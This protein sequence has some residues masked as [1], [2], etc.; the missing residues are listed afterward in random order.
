MASKSVFIRKA[1]LL[2]TAAPAVLLLVSPAMA[3]DQ[4]AA[5]ATAAPVDPQMQSA[6]QG[7]QSQDIV[8]TGS[9]FRR[10][11]TETP[12]PVT[13]L[14]TENLQRAGITN[15]ADAVRSISADNSG[16]IP[17]AF[18]G[19]FGSGSAGV[20]LRGL[21]V[22]STLVL[23]DGIRTTN[24]PAADDGQRS[25]VDLNSIPRSTIDRIE[26]LKDGASSTY[27]AD[28][29]GGVVNIITRKEIKGIEGTVEGGISQRGDGGEQ[30]LTLTA[31]Y[32]DLS[33]QGF[34]VYLNGEYEH[35][36]L[37]GVADR[38]FPYNTTDLTSIGG[39]NNNVGAFGAF[40]ARVGTIS[41]VVRP[42]TQLIPGNPY[43]GV[44][45]PNT[46][47]Q[48]LNPAG[49]AVGTIARNDPTTLEN[50]GN[51][52][53]Y[54]E[55]NQA[56][57]GTIAPEQTRYGFTGHA[58]I[59]VGADSQ[60]YVTGSY[61]HSTVFS[62]NSAPT[63]IRQRNPINSTNIVLPALLANGSINPQDPYANII[64][65]VT[66]Q[67]EAAQIQYA[68]GDIPATF[69]SDNNVY[70]LAAG[71]SGKFGQGWSYS[72]DAT[73]ARSDLTGVNKGY[74]SISGLADAINNGTYNFI[75]P[76]Q[77]SQAVRNS[78]APDVISK[79]KSEMYM[80]QAVVTKDLFN[81]PG[82]PLQIGV[83]G[84]IRRETLDNPNAN[85]SL[86]FLGLNAVSAS[87][88][89]TVSA[90]FFEI[91][92]PLLD[93]LEI[94]ASGRYD[95]YSDGF[96]RFSPKVGVKVTPFKSLA[97]R[98]TFS[99]GFR[100]PS[101]AESQKG[102]VIGYTTATPPCSVIIAHGGVSTGTDP[103]GNPTCSG[104]NG[105][106]Q[107]YSIGYNN[108]SNPS[109]KPEKSRSFTGGA[110]F[111]PTHWLS[112]TA[113]YYNIKKTDVISGGPESGAALANY[114]DGQP[115]PAGYSVTLDDPD[116]QFP[117]A[118]RKVLIVNSPYANASALKTSGIDVSVQ[119]DFKFGENNRFTSR[120]EGTEILT[121]DFKPSATA[122]YDHYVGT[123]APYA[124]SSGSG[125]PRWRA[126]WQ[127]SLQLGAFT[128]TGTGYY[129][130]GYKSVAVDQNGPTAIT[131][132]DSLYGAGANFCHTKGFFDLD[133]VGQ[134]KVNDKFSFYMNAINV[135]D[136]KPP[137]NPANYAAVNYNATWSQAGI[138][139]RYFR[140]GANFKF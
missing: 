83:G 55:Q 105:Y 126:N 10:P 111:Q 135:L 26:V 16:S 112:F 104:G 107:A 3:Q 100:A 140:V 47:S 131:C 108:A 4:P 97:L 70:R 68:F 18:A 53:A 29:I 77:N 94:N 133:L 106:V 1:H 32:G 136:A 130:S 5:P 22:N 132:T 44:A 40:G 35:D 125:T 117:N 14:S 88:K 91:N 110:I 9:L 95:H 71:I 30:R 79:A 138:I 114:Y 69:K 46:L 78:I 90:A 15:I 121:F 124:I 42:A 11:D 134:V 122:G 123:Q 2:A 67:R 58:T 39:L 129:T 80:A 60:A 50:G 27:G 96:G 48:V 52:G 81:L 54:C 82:G 21:S 72:F 7:D 37:I 43:S 101:F 51:G 85:A 139:G 103:D 62:T 109:L 113:D 87:G 75:D 61:Y 86:D 12:S 33:E 38:K 41:A 45:L 92:A 84:A 128:I 36:A 73:Y 120:L 6:D 20:S 102:A 25:F 31:G 116:P 63:M 89:R 76:S 127:N 59:Q 137:L 13:I 64:D 93:Q 74:L 65:P 56:P 23:I 28:A 17:T 8:V 115:L 24:Y 49:C 57:Y 34:N 98:G 99:K 66:G 19:G 119:A 118:I